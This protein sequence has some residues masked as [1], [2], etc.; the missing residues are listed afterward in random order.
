MRHDE[1]NTLLSD[2]IH[3]IYVELSKLQEILKNI[4]EKNRNLEIARAMLKDGESIDKITRYTGLT[5]SE[6]EHLHTQI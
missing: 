5:Q 3:V 6:L 4:G 1:D 2:A